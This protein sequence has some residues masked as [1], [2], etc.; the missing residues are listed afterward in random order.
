TS[1]APPSGPSR[2]ASASLGPWTQ[3]RS[4]S[5]ATAALR[6]PSATYRLQFNLGFRF[7][8]AREL[9]DYLYDLGVSD[10]YASPRF[11][12]RRG[13]S[14]GYDVAN[15]MRVNSELGTEDDFDDLVARLHDYRMGLVLDIVPNHMAASAENPWWL[16]VLENGPS[17]EFAEY[18]DIDWHPAASKSA[19]LHN[20]KVMLPILGNVY[21]TVLLNQELALKIDERGLHLRYYEH[22]M[23]I[24]PKTY[25]A[26]LEGCGEDNG[27]GRLRTLIEELPEYTETEPARAAR[28]REWK[29]AVKR[30]LWRLYLGGGAVRESI[31]AACFTRL[32]NSCPLCAHV[33]RC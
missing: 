31:D 3:N 8:D 27:W 29:E 22:R 25:G 18:F 16:D 14:H 19:C 7:P 1:L 26:V 5:C 20:G 9:V 17:S 24:D 28:R 10:V 4:S 32:G 2:T 23:P 13:S 11:T 6:V 33:L 21:G 12:A 15:V 30:E